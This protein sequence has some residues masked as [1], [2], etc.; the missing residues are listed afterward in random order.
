MNGFYNTTLLVGGR[1]N[2]PMLPV[3]A[4][5]DLFLGLANAFSVTGT[6][7]IQQIDTTDF[8][9]GTIITLMF[10][11]TTRLV[12]GINSGPGNLRGLVL[13]KVALML[14]ET[15]MRVSRSS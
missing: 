2:T 5:A 8:V 3:T 1:L 7:H 4:A 12:Y 15:C 14:T 11:S 9:D 6:T 13:K 10:E